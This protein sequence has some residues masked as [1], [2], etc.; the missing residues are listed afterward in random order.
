MIKSKEV[1]YA[2][3]ASALSTVFLVTGFYLQ[4]ME[5]FWYFMATLA[6]M[7]PLSKGYARTAVFSYFVSSFLALLLC[8]FQFIYLMPYV[9]FMGLHPAVDYI[10][11][12]RGL[13][14][15]LA[16]LIKAAW[17]DA[18]V[19]VL[20]LFTNLFLFIDLM[21]GTFVII[22]VF[23]VC[24]FLYFLYDYAIHLLMKVL[25]KKFQHYS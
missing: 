5:F 18:S 8:G 13:N 6:L 9:I 7:I 3:I 11:R 12:K 21:A 20:I 17:F 23:V 10:M 24:T 4:I 2:A 1:A 15:C 16:H 19:Y 22:I 25:G 14:I